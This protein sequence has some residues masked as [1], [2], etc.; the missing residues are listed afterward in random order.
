MIELS[1]L[2]IRLPA[3]IAISQSYVG[4]NTMQKK[5]K[6]DHIQFQGCQLIP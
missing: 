1:R 5:R 6:P 3:F 2:I 4:K